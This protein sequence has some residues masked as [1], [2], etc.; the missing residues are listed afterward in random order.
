MYGIVIDATRPHQNPK[1]GKYAIYVKVIDESMH[2]KED[3]DLALNIGSLAAA[4]RFQDNMP[5]SSPNNY[6]VSIAIYSSRLETLPKIGRVGDIIRIHR[7]NISQYT[8]NGRQYKT[9]FVNIDYGSSWLLFKGASTQEAP[10]DPPEINEGFETPLI[11]P[12]ISSRADFSLNPQ[13]ND[14][15]KSLIDFTR[16]YMAKQ[17]VYE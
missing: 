1:T 7:A 11:Q 12:Y 13:D 5:A 2:Y 4:R 9:F 17:S 14:I 10:E 15:L 6:A 3:E 16:E 8:T